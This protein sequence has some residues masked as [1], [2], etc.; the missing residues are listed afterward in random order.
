MSARGPADH[1]ARSRRALHHA[2]ARGA[3]F[4]T[5]N[6]DDYLALRPEGEHPGIIILIRRRSRTAEIAGM[7]ALLA[8]AGEQGV[9]NNV[10]FA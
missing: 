9:A 10:N 6:R 3:I 7:Q 4:I 8:G 1:C 2:Y 5:C